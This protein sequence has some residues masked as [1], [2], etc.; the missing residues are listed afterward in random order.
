MGTC[1]DSSSTF[2]MTSFPF[3]STQMNLSL[4]TVSSPPCVLVASALAL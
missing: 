2:I 3:C 4:P 1:L